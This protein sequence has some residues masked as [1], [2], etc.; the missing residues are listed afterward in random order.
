MIAITTNNSIN[1]KLFFFIPVSLSFSFD[2]LR[3][4]N[5]F[6]D[7]ELKVE[8]VKYLFDIFVENKVQM[9]MYW[10]Y[11][12]K[13]FL[14]ADPDT[15]ANDKSNGVEW[16]FDENSFKKFVFDKIAECNEALN[17]E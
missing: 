10:N 15:N 7:A 2:G 11:D 8:K 14:S 3:P 1:V 4:E 13:A 5:P 9:A 16:S 17:K 6:P 12:P